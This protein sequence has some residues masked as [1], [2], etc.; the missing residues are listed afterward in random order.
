MMRLSRPRRW[1]TRIVLALL[2][3]SALGVLVLRLVPAPPLRTAISSSIAVYADGGELLRLTVATD[4]QY[5]LWVPLAAIAPRTRDAV[6]LYEDRWFFWHPGVNPVALVRSA[7]A[8]YGHGRRQGGSTITMQLARRLYR[9]DTRTVPGKLRQ[10][11]AALWI[12]LRHGKREIL[13]A[14]LNLAPFGGNVEGVGAASLVYFRKRAAD[15]TLTEGL[16]LAVIPQNPRRRVIAEHESE[17]LLAARERL[18]R[19]WRAWHSDDDSFASDM[20][21]PI[22]L[23]MPG[24][25]PFRAPHAVEALLR[26][27]RGTEPEIWSTIDLRLQTTV[28]R[29]VR[30][31][32]DAERGIGITNATAIL[33]DTTDMTVKALLGSADYFDASIDGQV[34]G[35]AAKRSPGSTLKPFVYALGLDQGVLHPMTVLRDVP[36]AFGPFTPE[37]FDGRFVGPITAQEALVRSRNIPA[38]AVAARL[39]QPGLYDFLKSAGVANMLPET[40]YGLALVLGGGDMTME[41][42]ARL[43]AMLANGGVLRSLRTTR[44]ADVVRGPRLLSAEA[45]FITLDMLRHAPRPDTGA[46]SERAVAWKTGTSWGFRDAWAAGVFGRYV[47]LVWVGNFDGSSNPAFIG[48]TA[49]APLFFR[50]VDSVRGQTP[51]TSDA[52]RVPPATLSRVEVCAASGDLPNEHCP[53]RADTWFIPGKSPIRV[54][55]LHRSVL[56]D[57]RTGRATCGETSTTRQEIHEFWSSD[58]LRL[59]RE[60]GMP[61]R[62]PP[63]QPACAARFV[64]ATDGEAPQIT[65]PLRGAVYTMRLSHPGTV[66]LRATH[67]ARRRTLYWFVNQGFLGGAQADES[68]R[69]TPASPGRYTVRVV[70]DAGQSDA[71]EVTVDLVP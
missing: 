68:V 12:E 36:T 26:R 55:T 43:Y 22:H 21:L 71:R 41:E 53:E 46:P 8:T 7:M 14:H 18:W 29:M 13:E 56:V 51:A 3:A 54:S 33:V 57:T 69:W 59:F 20:S 61:R 17:A 35:V 42:L 2:A 62:A 38:V 34:N 52:W 63:S 30:Q 23:A 4:A 58:M 5:R 10:V 24:E 45:A 67:A 70:D 16:T 48:V 28:E 11:A 64:D 39:A 25:L 40:H 9:L 50:I 47:L 44:G 15:L 65:S 32:V 66:E 1:S 31:Y 19:L 60:A 27:S 49:A 37:N 6:L